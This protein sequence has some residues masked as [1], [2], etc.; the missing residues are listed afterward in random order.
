MEDKV[1]AQKAALEL[2]VDFL[3]DGL[4]N[5]FG[6]TMVDVLAT[7]ATT[8]M[9]RRSVLQ[10]VG[11]SEMVADMLTELISVEAATE[12]ALDRAYVRRM[13]QVRARYAQLNAVFNTLDWINES[14][15]DWFADIES[16]DGAYLD[17]ELMRDSM[18][19]WFG[20]PLISSDYD[21]DLNEFGL[22]VIQPTLD[23]WR[24]L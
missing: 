14:T 1:A 7:T 12:E 8:R 23:K 19:E 2:V 20:Q 17:L 10:R 5:H 15:F 11:R 6:E 13:A 3:L 18:L 16:T 9:S 4:P 21:R 24:S 22:K